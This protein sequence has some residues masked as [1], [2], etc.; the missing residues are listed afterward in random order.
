MH[1]YVGLSLV[2][3]AFPS[4]QFPAYPLPLVVFR[5][6]AIVGVRIPL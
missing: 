1:R 5:Y 4:I 3:S 2:R 6:V